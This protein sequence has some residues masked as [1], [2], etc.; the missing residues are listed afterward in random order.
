MKH[1][2]RLA[3]LGLPLLAKAAFAQGFA[4]RPVRVVVGFA[5]GGGSDITARIIADEMQKHL[6]QPIFVDNRAGAGGLIGA[7]YVAQSAPTGNTLYFG[8]GT[9]ISSIYQPDPLD[10]RK[11]FE[12][13][14]NLTMGG[15]VVLA[16]T[17]APFKSLPELIRFAHDNPGKLNL[18]ISSSP[19]RLGMGVFAD[20]TKMKYTE[21]QYKGDAA[22]VL[23]LLGGEIN[24]AITSIIVAQPHLE[25]GKFIP[26]FV[27][28]SRR[29]QLLP[30]VPTAVELGVKDAVLEFNLGLW[31]PKGTPRDAINKLQAAAAAALKDKQVIQ[32]L[33]RNGAEPVGSTP[34][35]Q[36]RTYDDEMRFLREAVRITGFKPAG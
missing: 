20:R 25:A 18:G 35:E 9:S 28:S 3:L 11:D 15:A 27:T 12:P 17:D 8:S 29:S 4:E 36:M 30:D 1:R 34:E 31:A 2:S 13:I 23:G 21:I 5:P 10:V 16:R 19:L 6:G 22:A 14:S 7:R 26:L 32:K 24:L 33:V